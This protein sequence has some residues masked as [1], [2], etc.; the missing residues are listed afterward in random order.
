MLNV[1]GAIHQVFKDFFQQQLNWYLVVCK[2][3]K[4]FRHILYILDKLVLPDGQSKV[5]IRLRHLAL[6]T[7]QVRWETIDKFPRSRLRQLRFA[8]TESELC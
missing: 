5:K 7:V 6:T 3:K 4:F 2:D 1:G 8:N